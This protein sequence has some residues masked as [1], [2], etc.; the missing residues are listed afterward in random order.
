MSL[1]IFLDVVFG[2]LILSSFQHYFSYFLLNF[3]KVCLRIDSNRYYCRT[4]LS[5]DKVG[6]WFRKEVRV[7]LYICLPLPGTVTLALCFLVIP[8]SSIKS[9]TFWLFL[10]KG[11][12][13]SSWRSKPWRSSK[14]Q[15]HQQP[16]CNLNKTK[17]H[18]QLIVNLPIPKRLA[19]YLYIIWWFGSFV[20]TS[21]IL[22][23]I[24]N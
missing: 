24:S 21:Q 8:T 5:C 16:K 4:Y 2:C 3:S 15:Q 1:K 9:S 7:A 20:K 22:L 18:I 19:A 17:L 12:S 10:S 6:S 23:A 13:F 11:L 14:Q